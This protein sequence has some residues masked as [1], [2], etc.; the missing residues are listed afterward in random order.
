MIKKNL[1]NFYTL[2]RKNKNR[3]SLLFI[4][5][6]I[7]IFFDVVSIGTIFPFLNE[8]LGNNSSTF[9]FSNYQLFD[10][11]VGTNNKLLIF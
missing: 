11:V 9:N 7:S 3:L 5:M 4:F 1:N 6:L 10:E 2:T 8:L